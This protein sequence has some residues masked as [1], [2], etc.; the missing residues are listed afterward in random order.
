MRYRTLGRTGIKVSPYALGAMMFGA[1]IGNPDHDDGYC[2]RSGP[3][4]RCGVS[5]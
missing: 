1:A 4:F 5:H 3:P 2:G